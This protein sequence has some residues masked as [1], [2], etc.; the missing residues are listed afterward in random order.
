M[1]KFTNEQIKKLVEKY[2]YIKPV[3]V[4]T[5]ETPEDYDYSYYV[6]DSVELPA[7]WTRL[8]LLM[9]KNIKPHAE[10]LGS[11]FY[12]TQVKEK[13]GMLCAYTSVTSEKLSHD[14]LM[15]EHFSSYVC[16]RCGKEARY[17]TTGWIENLC[18]DC[19]QSD[20]LSFSNKIYRQSY[21]TVDRFNSSGV[22]RIRYSFRPIR[23]EYNHVKNMTDQEFFEYLMA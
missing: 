9:C 2:P 5:N 4:W 16:M 1:T 6:G 7:G 3:N 19:I 18:T 14:I 13:Y 22:C 8:F 11:D 15:Y 23:T 10:K 12:F 21:T 20:A 17:E